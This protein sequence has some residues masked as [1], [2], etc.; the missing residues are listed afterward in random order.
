[1]LSINVNGYL[2]ECVSVYPCVRVYVWE[3][4]CVCGVMPSNV[5]SLWQLLIVPP[6]LCLLSSFSCFNSLSVS[7]ITS[8]S[9]RLSP[10]PLLLFSLSHSLYDFKKKPSNT[11]YY[12]HEI[13]MELTTFKL[14]NSS[15]LQLLIPAAHKVEWY[16]NFVPTENAC[17]SILYAF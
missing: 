9:L 3:C 2:C 4:V 16:F 12:M 1:M 15:E 5:R 13:L 17:I 6:V 8:F 14:W 7:L 10:F 11:L